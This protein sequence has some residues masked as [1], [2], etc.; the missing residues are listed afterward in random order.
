MTRA[1]I[2]IKAYSCYPAWVPNC[3]TLSYKSLVLAWA[4]ALSPTV[5][6]AQSLSDSDPLQ[7]G[8]AVADFQP[9]RQV[10]GG[11]FEVTPTGDVLGLFIP[12]G[13]RTASGMALP[14]E[15]QLHDKRGDRALKGEQAGATGGKGYVKS[16]EG[17]FVAVVSRDRAKRTSDTEIFDLSGKRV[18][19]LAEHVVAVSR[20]ARFAA[21]NGHARVAEVLS[22]NIIDL[23]IPGDAR[24][25]GLQ[26]AEDSDAF[27]STYRREKELFV[28]AFSSEG[29]PLW[30]K[31]VMTGN[32]P[33]IR[34]SLFS[35][36]GDYIA[37][38]A[39][40]LPTDHI[41]LYDS[42]GKALWTK[43]LPPGNY[44]MAFAADG[45]KLLLINRDGHVLF[46]VTDG[47]VLWEKP[48]P[49][50]EIERD[51]AL[52]ATKILLAGNKFVVASRS[53]LSAEAGKKPHETT[54]RIS[55]P[56]L[57]Y[58]ID[59]AGQFKMLLNR[60]SGAFLTEAGRFHYEPIVALGGEPSAVYYLTKRGLRRKSL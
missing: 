5:A 35:P 39:G 15:I 43:D 23:A 11:A 29:K 32:E 44:A 55:G 56:D 40:E 7:D 38:V 36:A 4:V 18:A 59:L 8:V 6:L 58:T 30:R 57:I 24:N 9:Q 41:T 37:I 60:P 27:V 53:A 20:N 45:D 48:F 1:G 22:G 31:P 13:K 14:D 47:T 42:T 50:A 28:S 19:R 26:F 49:V 12:V 51:G 2:D 16:R 52:I 3:P 17:R 54:N 10:F 33:C 34:N 21:L 25:P 46:N